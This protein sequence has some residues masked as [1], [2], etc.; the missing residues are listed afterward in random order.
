VSEALAHRQ[1]KSRSLTVEPAVPADMPSLTRADALVLTTAA[2]VWT[3]AVGALAVWRHDHFL[4]HRFD[5]GN[6]VQ[7]VWSSAHGRLLEMT[8]ATTGEQTARLAAHVDPALLLVVPFWWAHPEPATLIV[9]QAAALAAGVYPVARLALAHT[10]SRQVAWLLSAWYL[11]FPWVLWNAINDFHPVTLAIPLLLY[12]IWFLDQ[13]HLGRFAA[14]AGLALLTGELVGLTVAGLGLWYAFG[15]RRYRA[16]LGIAAVGAG[17]TAVCVAFVIPAF[18]DGPNRYYGRFE[19]VGGSPTGLAK[20]L[21]TDPGAVVDAIATGTDL[22][23]VAMLLLPTAFIALGAPLLLIAA[24][25]QLG[26]NML[27]DYW[28]STQPQYQYVTPL[29]PVVVAATIMTLRRFTPRGRLA[30]SAVLLVAAIT[31]LIVWPPIPGG[32]QYLFSD[33]EPPERIAAMTAAVRLIPPGAPVT[34][35]NRLGAHLSERE[36]VYTV[37]RRSRSEWIAIDIRDTG[38]EGVD[39]DGFAFFV[40]QLDAD[41]RWTRVF[42]REGVRVYRRVS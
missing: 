2:A 19:S 12:A 9:V 27:S 5:L 32:H 13:H 26:I 7:A 10:G 31:C 28:A 36:A 15:H 11:A 23:Y 35:S 33:P 3:A 42:D 37:P 30:Q 17:W 38:F 25:P 16:G 14:V 22:R 24:I 40:K 39:K 8:D 41:A 18:H 34:V 29:I 20:T 21:V 6:M 4:S 1:R